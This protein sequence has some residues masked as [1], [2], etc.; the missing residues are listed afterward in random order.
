MP[1]FSFVRGILMHSSLGATVEGL[2]LGFGPINFWTRK[3]FEG[4]D[5]LYLQAQWQR[6]GFFL[7]SVLFIL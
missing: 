3:K 6:W 5:A 2:P 1:Q 7:R 4:C